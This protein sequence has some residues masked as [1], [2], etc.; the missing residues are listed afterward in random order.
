MNRRKITRR[1]FLRVSAAATAGMVLGAC[2]APTTSSPTAETEP[3]EALEPTTTAV[4]GA[5]TEAPEPTATTVP[6]P[7]TKYRESPML[8]KLVEAGELPSVDERLPMNP[9]ILEPRERLGETIGRYGGTITTMGLDPN[10]G[11][12]GAEWADLDRWFHPEGGAMWDLADRAFKPN[13]LESWELSEDL[14][15]LTMHIRKG[16]RWSDGEPM[17]TADVEFWWEDIMLN[18]QLNPTLPMY[19]APDGNAMAVDIID[20]YTFAFVY[21]DSFAPAADQMTFQPWAP[22]HYLQNWHIKY[23]EQA[24]SVAQEEGFGDWWEAFLAHQDEVEYAG[25]LPVLN[26]YVVG[27]ADSA[28]NRLCGRNPYYWKVDPEGNQ[29]PYV[30][31]Y[32]RIL[33]GSREVMEAKAVAGDYNFGGAWADLK[34][35]PLLKDNEA[36]AGYTVRL[37]ESY[38]WGGSICWTF[39]YT[40]KDP[41][42]REI[43]NDLRFRRAMSHAIDRHEFNEIYN[44]GL[45]EIRQALPP[46]DWSFGHN[47]EWGHMYTEY[48]VD[49]ANQLLDEIGLEWDQNREW[50]LRPDGERLILQTVIGTE[51]HREGEFEFLVDAW[52]KVGVGV[53]WNQVD[54][55]LYTQ[56]LLANELDIGTWGAGGPSE[57]VGHAVIPIRLVPPWHWRGCC[58]LA[59]I[60]W[61]DWWESDGERGE[62]PPEVI[63]ELYNV[64]DEWKAEPMGTER[65]LELGNEMVRI[66]AENLWWFVVTG[67]A[68]GIASAICATAVANE[69]R[70][71]R[72]PNADGGWWREELLWIEA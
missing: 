31:Y 37:Y 11:A 23:N 14:R 54:Q 59:G 6:E 8:A 19:F 63:K 10:A 48:D 4:E 1:E 49:L 17:T 28:G 47:E 35:Y 56:R 51:G 7:S 9:L 12:F 66:N 24:D 39:N 44:L 62:E 21:Q 55:Q 5:T 29:L 61:Y 36:E 20:D 26:S 71:L 30:D 64:L 65:Y 15:V 50:R 25:E 72:D 27:Q 60:A 58:A 22:K 53:K 42:L 69:V 34:N 45:A 32:E 3:T 57:S 67:P 40:S 18:E 70:N 38:T 33:V 41:V 16:I 52:E 2:R 68:P 13:I 46:A 43:F